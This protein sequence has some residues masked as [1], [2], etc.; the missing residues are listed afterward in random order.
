MKN[1]LTKYFGLLGLVFYYPLSIIAHIFV[2]I[3]LVLAM[4]VFLLVI[5]PITKNDTCP[6]WVNRLYDWYIGQ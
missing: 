4:I 2:A 5:A 6:S 1:L 3:I